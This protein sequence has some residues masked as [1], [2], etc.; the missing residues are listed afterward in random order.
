MTSYL[1]TTHVAKRA[2]LG[3]GVVLSISGDSSCRLFSPIFY[4]F[5][6]SSSNRDYFFSFSRHGH[7]RVLLGSYIFWWRIDDASLLFHIPSFNSMFLVSSSETTHGMFCPDFTQPFATIIPSAHLLQ[8]FRLVLR[9]C[10]FSRIPRWS[11]QPPFSLVFGSESLVSS[12]WVVVWSWRGS[13]S[14]CR[15]CH[16]LALI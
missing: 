13:C 2:W 3:C 9:G 12:S 1:L 7:L 6:D 4:P 8:L 10:G 11:S 5:M 15:Y 16:D 14:L